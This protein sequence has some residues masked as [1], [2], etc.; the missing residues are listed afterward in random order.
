MDRTRRVDRT[1]RRDERLPGDLPAEHALRPDGRADPEEHVRAQLF[2][3]E[4]RHEGV[5]RR[6]ADQSELVGGRLGPGRVRPV[7]TAVR[8]H[9]D[10]DP[11]LCS[12]R[13]LVEPG[14]P[15]GVPATI[16]T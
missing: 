11:I 1:A 10:N 8:R 7:P 2:Q 6:L 13:V 3:V 16:T 12:R 5:N 4:Q 14:V 15:A 9:D